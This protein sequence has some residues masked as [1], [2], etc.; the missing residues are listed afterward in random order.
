MKSEKQM[1]KF[2]NSNNNS[3]PWARLDARTGI[4]FI[5]SSDGDKQ[6]VDL[7][8]KVIAL[9]IQNATQGW[10]A[11]DAAGADWHPVNGAWGNPPSE[12]H[13]PGVDLR[14]YSATAFGDSPIRAMRG[15]SRGFTGFISEVEERVLAALDGNQAPAGTWPTIKINAVT[16]VKA[17]QGST[18]SVGFT[19]AP[20]DKWASP[21]GASAPAKAVPVAKTAGMADEEF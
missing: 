8:N 4:L 12:N 5:S 6:A 19:L 16:V 1:L 14:I 2:P 9:D 21:E 11:V 3:G 18:I 10:L 15:N 13:K 7:K 17:G 20:I